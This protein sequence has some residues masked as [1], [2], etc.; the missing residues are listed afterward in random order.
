MKEVCELCGSNCD[1]D[2]V[3]CQNSQKW[4]RTGTCWEP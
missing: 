3:L 1:S 2:F 4:V